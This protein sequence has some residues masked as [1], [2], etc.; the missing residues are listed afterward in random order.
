MANLPFL[1]LYDHVIP[2]L[3]GAEEGIVDLH[4]RKMLKDF[5]RRTTAWREVIRVEILPDTQQ[6][7]LVPANPIARVSSVLRVGSGAGMRTLPALPEHA[8]P[9]P[10]YAGMGHRGWQVQNLP[11]IVLNTGDAH[12]DVL[13][14]L[15]LTI[16]PGV[17]EFPD[18]VLNNH[19]EIVASGVVAS[20]MA[21]PGKPWTQFEM[22]NVYFQRFVNG[23][24][25]LRAELRD[26][27][28]PNASTITG[29]R[30]GA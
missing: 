24:L 28:Q 9:A 6:Y 30:F 10:G 5:F 21:M 17:M 13:C 18:W 22:A 4:I 3:P 14:A 11:Y 23:V 20:M 2:Y 19:A 1:D 15:T 29:P 12:A 7:L 16:E 27:G 26:G 8:R 25:G